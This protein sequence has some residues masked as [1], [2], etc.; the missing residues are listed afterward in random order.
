MTLQERERISEPWVAT[1]S[2][3]FEELAAI[4]SYPDSFRGIKT[5]DLGGGGSDLTP[6]I[7]EKGGDAYSIDKRY[8]EPTDELE[9]ELKRN[10]QFLINKNGESWI[11]WAEKQE[12]AYKS[13]FSSRKANPQRYIASQFDTLPFPNN[14]FDY[15]FSH[16]SLIP[17][18]DFD[19]E[20]LVTE[21]A[22]SLRV[23]K[24]G[25]QFQIFPFFD[26]QENTDNVNP[27]YL[28]KVNQVYNQRQENQKSLLARIKNSHLYDYS[29]Q[30][31]KNGNLLTITKLMLSEVRF[32]EY[33]EH[34][35]RRNGD[36]T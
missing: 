18:R 14:I 15:I 34:L 32:R 33:Q 35:S 17:Y 6:T 5:L 8:S 11:P 20:V 25:G 9:T 19:L 28:P 1:S 2:R 36:Y 22:E 10:I 13:F 26:P 12:K 21:T 23:L 24:E 7:L 3:S 30:P 29:L 31:R 4:F 27:E 16:K